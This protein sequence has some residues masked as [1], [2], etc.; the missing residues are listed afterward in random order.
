MA[1]CMVCTKHVQRVNATRVHGMF[2]WLC[3]ESC[4]RLAIH[5][6]NR[7]AKTMKEREVSDD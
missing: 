7:Y 5:A 3:S 1:K 2:F 6:M 4:K